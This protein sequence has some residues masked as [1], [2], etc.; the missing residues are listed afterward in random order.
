MDDLARL[1]ALHG[2]ATTYRPAED[3]TVRVPEATVKALLGLLGVVADDAEDVR[4]CAEDAVRE[5]AERLLPRT[6]VL[7]QGSPYR[8]SPP[9]CRRAPGCGWPQRRRGRS[10]RGAPDSRS[11]CT[12]SPPRLRTAAPGPPP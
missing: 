5:A 4:V 8:R 9:G 11:A 1:A 2:I 12:G 10:S 3:V 6:V 7:W